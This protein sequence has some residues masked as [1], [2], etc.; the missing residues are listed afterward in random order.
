MMLADSS[1]RQMFAQLLG[2]G[3][4][5][6]AHHDLRPPCTNSIA[7]WFAR[8]ASLKVARLRRK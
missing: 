5:D 4:Q 2:L 8:A 6:I 7:S 3:N 1:C